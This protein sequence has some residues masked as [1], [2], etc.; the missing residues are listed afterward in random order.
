MMEHCNVVYK[1][2]CLDCDVSY[3]G[4]M[5]K[6]VKTKTKEHKRILR[7]ITVL[8]SIR[9]SGIWT[10]IRLGEYFII[11]FRAMFSKKTHVWNDIH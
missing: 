5:K 10:W 8:G 9:A 4:Q 7:D 6:K 3:I 2:S 11:R 1:I